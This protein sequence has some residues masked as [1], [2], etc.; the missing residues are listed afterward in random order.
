MRIAIVSPGFGYGGSYIVAANIGKALAKNNEVYYEAFKWTTNYSKVPDD[1]L[2]FFGQPVGILRKYRDKAGKAIELGLHHGFTPSKYVGPELKALLARLDQNHIDVVILN[3]FQSVVRFAEPLH[4]LRP[5]I[6]T[7]GWMH[8]ATSFSFGDLTHNYRAAFEH[9]LSS[10]DQ[11][12]CL[13]HTDY[14]KFKTLNDHVR[15]IYNP[16]KLAPHGTAD[17]SSHAIAFTTRLNIQIKGLDY[18]IQVANG[19]PDG[20][21]IELAGQG[22]PEEEVAFK[23]LLKTAKPGK[24]NYRGALS[25]QVLADHY[26]RCSMFLSTSRTEALPLV[27]IEAMSF[28]LPVISFDHDGGKEIL[29]NGQ[30]GLLAPIGDVDAMLRE[31]KRLA[32][33]SAERERLSQA[34]LKRYQDFE[35]TPILTDWDELFEGIMQ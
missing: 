10:L 14:N 9:S 18:L 4:R 28:G 6:K 16:V 2:N 34:S 31:I 32:D 5:E 1:R 15:V 35:L 29:Q 3:T 21:H 17:L 22:K 23:E 8:E 27:L 26:Q 11:I 25:G 30:S 12:V 7:I 19:L 24:I 13:T 20:W 33:S